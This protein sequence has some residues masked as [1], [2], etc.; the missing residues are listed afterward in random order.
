MNKLETPFRLPVPVYLRRRAVR[1]RAQVSGAVVQSHVHL[2]P[3]SNTATHALPDNFP[4]EIPNRD[5][6][7][8][9]DYGTHGHADARTDATPHRV[10]REST[11]MRFYRG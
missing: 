9:A 4:N 11:G 1:A 7:T 6:D 5:T 3:R 2:L 8:C 10:I